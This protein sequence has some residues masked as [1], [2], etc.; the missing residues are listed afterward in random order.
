[1]CGRRGFFR[2]LA[3]RA[4]L[5]GLAWTFLFYSPAGCS[6]PGRRPFYDI[7]IRGGRL[8]DGSGNPWYSADV[9]I[10]GDRIA[11]VG[12]LGGAGAGQVV[13]AKGLYIAPGFIDVH[14]HAASGLVTEARSAA[15]PLLA[16]GITTVL[17]NP[18]GGGPIDLV[19]QRERLLEHGLGVN[20]GQQIGHNAIRR[21]VIG[22]EDRAPTAGELEE[23]QA[24]VRAGMEAGAFG[25]SSGPFYAPGSYSTTEEIVALAR[26][27]ARYGGTHQSHLR[28]ESDY[29]IGL[30][31]AVREL[32]AVSRETGIRGIHTHIK[33]LGPHVWGDAGE[34]VRLIEGARGEGLEIFADQYPYEASSTGLGAA[35]LPRW[36]QVGGREAMLG[37]F[38]DSGTME[39]IRTAM[40]EN[41][42]RRGGAARIQF[43][44][45][46]PQPGIEGRT[47]EQVAA[48]MGLDPVDAAVELLR[49]GAPSIVSFNMR[50]DDIRTF[51]R[52][53]WTMTASDG[54]LPRMGEG[55][56][57]PRAYGTFPRKIRKYVLDEGVV[58]LPFAIRSMTSLPATVFGI[59][60]RGTIR[61]GS[62]ADVVV[63]DLV[64]LRDA[65]TYTE[66]H[67]LSEGMLHV[68]VNGRFAIREG[69]FTGELAG[70]MLYRRKGSS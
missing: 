58:D 8:L 25:L 56:P 17:V 44:R 26:V 61:P 65:A 24:L 54:S 68:L 62:F 4:G 35:L 9:G 41:L 55:V 52:R 15:R 57:H 6:L 19:E 31:G 32:I 5:A 39:R 42:D 66:P 46:V 43:R 18:D 1:M 12:D 14:T 47:L 3:V 36:A 11:A 27:A 69:A 40:V 48:E 53:P 29:S 2:G 34:V 67:Q 50:E 51:M 59:E 49:S 30:L 28:D 45:F 16:Q 33:A 60:G 37:R 38:E 22:N 7:I 70:R 23:M 64:V 63:F 21:A 10:S 13:E 20:V